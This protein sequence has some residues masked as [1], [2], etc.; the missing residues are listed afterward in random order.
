ML[1]ECD[2]G[3]YAVIGDLTARLYA[4]VVTQGRAEQTLLHLLA[5]EIVEREDA[6]RVL[7]SRAS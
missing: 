6:A 2:D 4:Q 3:T 7:G 5:H 1:D